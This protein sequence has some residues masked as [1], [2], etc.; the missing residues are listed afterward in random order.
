MTNTESEEPDSS[1]KF[2]PPRTKV[3]QFTETIID[4]KVLFQIIKLKDSLVIYIND[5]SVPYCN[6]LTMATTT[7][8]SNSP[9]AT[10]LLGAVVNQGAVGMASRLTK[11]LNKTVFV[12]LNIEDTRFTTPL[13]EKK[14]GEEISKLNNLLSD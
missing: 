13:V 14:L 6:N 8:I 9:S 4:Q 1:I 12:S 11:R 5:I 10:L 2:V 3:Y 7:R